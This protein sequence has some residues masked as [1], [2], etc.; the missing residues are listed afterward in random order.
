MKLSDRIDMHLKRFESEEQG[1][2]AT[3]RRFYQGKFWDTEVEIL[4]NRRMYNAARLCSKNIIFPIADSAISSLLGPNMKVGAVGRNAESEL[5]APEA[6]SLMSYVFKACGFQ[7]EGALALVDAVLCKRGIFKTCWSVTDDLPVITA[8]DPATIFFDLSTRSIRNI[9]YW[10]EATMVPWDEFT[11]RVRDGQYIIPPSKMRDIQPQVYPTWLTKAGRGDEKLLNKAEWILVWEYYDR[12]ADV[13]IHYL[14]DY[15]LT[16]FQEKLPYI[17]YTMFTL[18]HNSVDCSGL[19]EVQ[20]VLEAQIAINDMMS[21]IK[22]VAY[23][24]IPRTAYDKGQ[25]IESELVAANKADVGDLVGFSPQDKEENSRRSFA[26]AFYQFPTPKIPESAKTL[27]AMQEENA[28]VTSALADA[29]R[30]QVANVRTAAE[31]AV[32]DSELRT[33]LSARNSHVAQAIEDVAKKS[34]WLCSKYMQTEKKVKIVGTQDFVGINFE[35]LQNIDVDFEVAASNPIRMTPAVQIQMLKDSAPLW[36]GSGYVDER[37]IVQD[38]MKS[39]GYGHVNLPIDRSQNAQV[40]NAQA[41]GIQGAMDAGGMVDPNMAAGSQM[42]AN[43]PPELQAQLMNGQAP[44]PDALPIMQD[45]MG[46][47]PIDPS[48]MN[49]QILGS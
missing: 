14:K 4:A 29:A 22:Q 46:Q 11:D 33:R 21:L 31:V 7:E 49:E 3:A 19:S 18:N 17:P 26:D 28:Q 2:F 42:L 27:I 45:T 36:K 1:E 32:I 16:V 41:A 37:A 30:G 15:N 38:M 8:R 9:G 39:I 35:R 40:A 47:Q 25:I 20:L 12:N 6:T 43:L 13:V 10:L 24:D 34:L 44:G 48:I 5:R 23:K